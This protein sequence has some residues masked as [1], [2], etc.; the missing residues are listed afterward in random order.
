MTIVT[1]ITIARNEHENKVS[2]YEKLYSR[3]RKVGWTPRRLPSGSLITR[4]ACRSL[5]RYASLEKHLLSRR[6]VTIIGS[7]T[8]RH[9]SPLYELTRLRARARLIIVSYAVHAARINAYAAIRV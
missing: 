9:L 3:G 6:N 5:F 8:S 7:A 1:C 4:R 2:R